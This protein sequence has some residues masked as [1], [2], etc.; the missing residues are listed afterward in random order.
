MLSFRFATKDDVDIYFKWT[1]DPSVREN[2]LAS[3]EINYKDHVKWFLSKLNSSNAFLYVFLNE[4]KESVGQVRIEKL[5]DRIFVGQSVDIKHRG[6]KYSSEML[7]KATDDY[8]I[9]FPK[10]T[11]IS[12]IKK[13][14]APSIKMSI[15]SGLIIVNTDDRCDELLVLKGNKQNDQGFIQA[16]KRLYNLI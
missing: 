3:S 12:V 8:L 16:S 5:K 7:K 13:N 14:N 1:N 9:K 6:K 4:K 15:N 2:S 10:D 11:I